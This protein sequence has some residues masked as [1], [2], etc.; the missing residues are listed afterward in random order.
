MRGALACGLLAFAMAAVL[1]SVASAK[2]E[3]GVKRSGF[4][5]FA[6]SLGAMTINRI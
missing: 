1:P 6:R 4:R 3:P 2:P 5:L